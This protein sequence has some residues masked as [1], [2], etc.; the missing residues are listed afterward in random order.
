MQSICVKVDEDVYQELEVRRG[1]ETKS[2]Y[3]RKIIDAYLSLGEYR[4]IQRVYDELK[5]EYDKI[6][7]IQEIQKARIEELQKMNGFLVQDHSRISG[8][9]DRLLMPSQEEQKEKGKKWF[10][11]WK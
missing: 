7:A 11:F 2:V 8:Q 6:Q 9:L 1:T 5:I 3:Y 10:E 4:N